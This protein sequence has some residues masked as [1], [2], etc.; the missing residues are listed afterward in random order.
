MTTTT[1]AARLNNTG[2]QSTSLRAGGVEFKHESIYEDLE[3]MRK[4]T[5]VY[6]PGLDG[7]GDYSLPSIRNLSVAYDVWRFEFDPN[8]R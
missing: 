4:H 2:A 5:I 7:V 1:T 6:V 3:S 8:D